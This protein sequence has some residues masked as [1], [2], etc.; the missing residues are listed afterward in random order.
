[1]GQDIWQNVPEC[2]VALAPWLLCVIIFPFY[3]ITHVTHTGKA[4]R[5]QIWW[6]LDLGLSASRAV[7]N[8]CLWFKHPVNGVCD[9]AKL[10]S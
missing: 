7:R 1:V 6:C 5:H 10:W 4:L 3:L 2:S 8:T 9:T